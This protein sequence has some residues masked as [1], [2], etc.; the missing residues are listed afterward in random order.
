MESL[1][2][3]LKSNGNDVEYIHIDNLYG[4]IDFSILKEYEKVNHIYIGAGNVTELVNLPENLMKLE[5]G[6][7]KISTLQNIPKKIV[8]IDVSHNLISSIE[9]KD[10]LKLEKLNCSGNK[11]KSLTHIPES[12]QELILDNNDVLSIDLN[13]LINLTKFECLNN[14]RISVKNI[15]SGLNVLFKGGVYEIDEGHDKVDYDDALKKYYKLKSEYALMKANSRSKDKLKI[16]KG[17][18][19]NKIELKCVRC[20]KSGGTL[21]DK[22][23]NVFTAKCGN[24]VTCFEMVLKADE[25]CGSTYRSDLYDNNF[26]LEYMKDAII[27]H[28]MDTMFSYLDSKTSIN[29]FKKKIEEYAE[30]SSSYL[31]SMKK[32]NEIF[33]NA[34][35]VDSILNETMEINLLLDNLSTIADEINNESTEDNRQSLTSDKIKLH[36]DISEK[37]KKLLDLKYENYGVEIKVGKNNGQISRLIEHEVGFRNS[38]LPEYNEVVKYVFNAI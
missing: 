15:P 2:E 10:L 18:R 12:I 1:L 23:K 29:I 17:K 35:R 37:K 3:Y 9:I 21:F 34:E 38:F 19:A 24:P 28:K 31:E 11:L 30:Y 26:L 7:N 16:K 27:K 33:N 4:I 36:M 8:E 25:F 6:R 13:G 32:Y 20:K 5:C 14:T 22:K